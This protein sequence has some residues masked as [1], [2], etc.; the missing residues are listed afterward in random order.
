[1]ARAEKIAD[2]TLHLGEVVF[3]ELAKGK[4]RI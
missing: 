1:M 3:D 4:P 2:L